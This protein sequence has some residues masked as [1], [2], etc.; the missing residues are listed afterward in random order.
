MSSVAGS[1]LPTSSDSSESPPLLSP[2]PP[3][4]SPTAQLLTAVKP[5]SPLVTPVKPVESMGKPSDLGIKPIINKD[6]WI[7]AKKIIDTHLCCS[8]FWPG[9]SKEMIITPENAAASVWWEEVVAYFC[10]PPVLDLFVKMPEFECK[11]FKMLAYINNHFNPSATVDTL[12]SIFDLINLKQKE[13]KQVVSLKARF[14]RVFATLKMG[15]ISINSAL[16]VGFML[17]ALLSRYQAV[18]QEFRV[19]RYSLANATLETVAEQCVHF[20][21]DPWS[22]PVGKDGTVPHSPSAYAVG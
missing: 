20:D 16:Q 6:S 4:T 19:G 15:G 7:E 8:P 10:K 5:E 12:S 2:T 14:S 13:D 1:L 21:K 22:G 11:G 18:I 3:V 9:P 17:H